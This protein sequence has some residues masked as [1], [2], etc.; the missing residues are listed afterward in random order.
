M[1]KTAAILTIL[2][3]SLS[4]H[5][6]AQCEPMNSPGTANNSDAT[7]RAPERKA[8]DESDWLPIL[9]A[10]ESGGGFTPGSQATAYAGVRMGIENVVLNLGY[11]RVRAHNGF[12]TQFSGMIPVFR[13]PGPQKNESRNYLRIY[14]EPGIGYRAGGGGFGGYLSGGVM[15]ALLSDKR[16]DLK[17][18]S[19][20]FEYQRRAPFAAPGHGDNRFTFGLM[21][22]LCSHCGFD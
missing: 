6:S 15:V 1:N 19:P 2:L 12:A 16:L 8:Y 18:L 17:G 4:I 11:D 3:F 21:L 20:Y 22:A 10:A 7:S 13:F 9:L 5:T 14:A